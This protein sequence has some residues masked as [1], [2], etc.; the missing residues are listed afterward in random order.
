MME[1]QAKEVG[2]KEIA[3]CQLSMVAEGLAMN[4][5]RTYFHNQK[6]FMRYLQEKSIE[7]L[8]EVTPETINQ[9]RIFISL[10]QP[11]KKPL[12]IRS[13]N[14]K[15]QAVKFLFAFLVREKNYL[16]DPT[17]HIRLHDPAKRKR[18]REVMTQKEM[19]RIL[20]AP[21]PEST[22]GLRDKA[23]L[24]LYYSSGMRN[25]E[26]R[27]LTV[28]DIDLES[29]TIRIRYPK[30]RGGDE[31]VPIGKVAAHYLEEYIKHARP[32]LLKNDLEETLFLNYQGKPLSIAF[33]PRAVQ[34]Y[35]RIAKIVRKTD[36]HT[37][38]HTCGTHLHENGA[39]IRAIQ[40]LLR[41]K[42]LDTTQIYV[43]VKTP[44]LRKVLEKTH[45]RERGIVNAP[46]VE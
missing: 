37:L 14:S 7:K 39:D 27:L 26:S 22:L 18:V 16:F 35:A 29:R 11:G 1:N 25:T 6:Q 19:I 8:S 4:T 2:I 20:N 46:P 12:A 5:R 31:V 28:N 13:Q 44:Q 15:M 17:S 32:K 42:S 36:A 41:H 3:D 24:E 9:Y 23:M 30:G 40:E 45:P 34:K 33:P 38:R 21:N 10:K 43:E